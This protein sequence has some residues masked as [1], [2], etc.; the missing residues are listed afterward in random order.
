M[1]EMECP[2]LEA[3]RIWWGRRSLSAYDPEADVRLSSGNFERNTRG[4][5][6]TS[7]YRQVAERQAR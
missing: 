5:G 3:K 1:I 2:R 4:S 7:R 6:L